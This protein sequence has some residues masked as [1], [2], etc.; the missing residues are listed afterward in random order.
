M[1]IM[2]TISDIL[3]DIDRGCAVNNMVEDGFSYR[4]VYFVN[5]NRTGKKYHV[6]TPYEN[7][8][9]SLENIIKGNLTTT[10]TVVISAVTA[11]KFGK[12][13]SLL[14][15][16]YGFSLNEYFRQVCRGCD[17][18]NGNGNRNITYGRYAYSAGR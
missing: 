6:D 11:L 4:I 18:S 13:V 10:N 16:A 3:A 15:R 14:D 8:R 2:F 1:E 12:C 9:Q 17:N 5:E 7:L